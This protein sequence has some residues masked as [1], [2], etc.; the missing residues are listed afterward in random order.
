MDN[1]NF[2]RVACRGLHSSTDPHIKTLARAMMDLNDWMDG[3]FTDRRK[4]FSTV[5]LM[6]ERLDS[7]DHRLRDLER[8]LA[9]V[10]RRL[11]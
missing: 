11:S 6:T 8:R 3:S 5:A 1:T 2:L 7:L 10:E 9:A 4:L